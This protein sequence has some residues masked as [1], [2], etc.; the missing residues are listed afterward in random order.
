MMADV[1]RAA[2]MTTNAKHVAS[3]FASNGQTEARPNEMTERTAIARIVC[4]GGH[5][6][7][8]FGACDDCYSRTDRI[9]AEHI[10]PLRQRAATLEALLMDAKGERDEARGEVV[11]Y[12]ALL[13]EA[14]ELIGDMLPEM[15][16]DA[17]LLPAV[18]VFLAKLHARKGSKE[19]T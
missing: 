14:E 16:F 6:V 4:K 19:T 12:E 9:I 15:P 3:E 8:P 2:A 18:G 13:A 7:G 5:Y 10:E 17:T 1:Q 11:E